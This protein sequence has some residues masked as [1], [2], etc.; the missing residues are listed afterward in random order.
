LTDEFFMGEQHQML[1]KI[2]PLVMHGFKGISPEMTLIVN[3][4][5]ELFNYSEPDEYR[6]PW[7]TTEIPYVWERRNG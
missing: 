6:L 2:P 5:T 7:N 3:V 1:L 4:P